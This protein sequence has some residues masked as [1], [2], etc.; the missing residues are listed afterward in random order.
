MVAPVLAFSV[1]ASAAPELYSTGP[2]ADSVFIRFV[3]ASPAPLEVVAQ[4]GQKPLRLDTTQPVS[5]LYPVDPDKLIKG[6]LISGDQKLP[7]RL[8]IKPGEFVTVFALTDGTGMKQAEVREQ[9]G[10][11]DFNGLKASL[12]FFNVD[13]SCT[14]AS[15][16]RAGRNA[17]LFK[18]VA[19][20]SVQRR[21][22]NPI[23][24]SVQLV[25]ANA[26]VG[27]ALDLGEL[28]AGERYSVMLV[29]SAKGPQL[30]KATDTLSH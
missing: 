23:K 24:L 17:D 29:P 20:G 22:I 5:L 8:R 9:P 19:V 13:K 16:R 27:P 4:P 11:D 10:D 3:N 30:I 21:P 15:L 12:A 18:A 28:K 25:C 7:V 26:N 1:L 14:D 2:D 6:T